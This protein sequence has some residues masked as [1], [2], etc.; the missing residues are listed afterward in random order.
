MFFISFLNEATA[1]TTRAAINYIIFKLIFI[2]MKAF[3]REMKEEESFRVLWHSDA[4]HKK[5]FTL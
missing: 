1:V 5:L 2:I 3:K 4:R